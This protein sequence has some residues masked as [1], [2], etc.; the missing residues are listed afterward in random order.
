MAERKEG[1][2]SWNLDIGPLSLGSNGV[3]VKPQCL[4]GA[5]V[6]NFNTSAGVSDVRGGQG[7]KLSATAEA[8]QSFA[9]TGASLGDFFKNVKAAD[10]IADDLINPLVQH[11]DDIVVQVLER[12]GVDISGPCEV[13]GVVKLKVGVGAGAAVALGWED[14]DGYRM[15]GVGGEAACALSLGFSVFAGLKDPR[16]RRN[17]KLIIDAANL[18]VAAKIRLPAEQ[19]DA[20]REAGSE[21]LVLAGGGNG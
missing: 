17:V 8:V 6:G 5:R 1:G 21:T 4:L 11:V 13:D 3:N 12:V 2:P 16:D 19:G 9:A 18:S 14:S 20:A 7:L 15:V 10:G